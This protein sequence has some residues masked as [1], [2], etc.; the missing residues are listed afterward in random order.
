[1]VAVRDGNVGSH[2]LPRVGVE[3]PYLRDPVDGRHQTFVDRERTHTG[4]DVPA[5]PVPLHERSIDGH[6]REGVV[7]VGVGSAGGPMIAI[8]DVMAREPPS[9]SICRRP[10]IP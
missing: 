7:D 4:R 3:D 5:V 10:G 2:D 8:F 9:P 1:M 6:L